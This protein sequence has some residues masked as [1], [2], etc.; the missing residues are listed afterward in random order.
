MALRH[1]LT[2]RP[3]SCYYAL[4]LALWR[5][6]DLPG[7]VAPYS[8]HRLVFG[9]DLV[10]FGEVA[11]TVPGDGAEDAQQFFFETCH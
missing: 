11:P 4:P 9:R 10:G 3:R 1:F 2:Q 7:L 5:S 8:P 6:S